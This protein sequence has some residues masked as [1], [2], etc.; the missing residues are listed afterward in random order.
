MSH[1][2]IIIDTG[3]LRPGLCAAYL[4][5]ENRRAALIDCGTATCAGR[6]LAALEAAGVAREAVDWLLVTHVHLD[7]AG[8][9]GPLIRALPNARL[10]VHPR[11]A[12]HM[13]D[14]TRLIAGARA[15]YGEAMFERDHAGMLPVPSERVV[16]AGDGHV[17]DLAGRE[18]LCV[19]TP[20]H[21]RH[22]YSVWDARTRSWFA[23]DAFGLSYREFDNDNGAFIVPTTSPVQFDP[24]EMKDSVRKLVARDPAAIHVAHYGAVTECARLA[25][26]MRVMVDAMVSIAQAAD[27]HEDRHARMVTGLTDLC[28]ERART[29]G[30]ADA[31]ARVAEV[32]GNDIEINAQGLGVWLDRLAK[33]RAG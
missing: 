9:A 33:T 25:D 14:P 23:G 27:G 28:V 4:L 8:A 31:Q 2:P 15:V 20:G 12:P 5:Q 30:V 6:V 11:G 24:D 7:H 22:H 3:Y 1:Q 13:I 19:D 18:L 29:H 16:V 21:A 26:D 32:L 10:V 17:V